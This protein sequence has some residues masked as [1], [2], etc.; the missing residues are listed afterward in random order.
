MKIKI[1]NKW[2]SSLSFKSKIKNGF[3]R[4]TTTCV[5]AGQNVRGMGITW[6]M[7]LSIPNSFCLRAWEKKQ[8]LASLEKWKKNKKKSGSIVT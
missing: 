3:R 7:I 2:L 5:L 8:I 6:S 1:G 4:K